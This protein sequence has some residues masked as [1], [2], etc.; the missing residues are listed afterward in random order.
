MVVL[1]GCG[2]AGLAQ[3]TFAVVAAGPETGKDGLEGHHPFEVRVFGLV[4]DA[5]AAG[6]RIFR[7]R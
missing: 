7:T 4:H 3:E 5:H 2:R 6:A 1:E